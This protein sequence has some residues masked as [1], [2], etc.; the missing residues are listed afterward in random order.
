M[1]NKNFIFYKPQSNTRE[2]FLDF[3]KTICIIFVVVVNTLDSVS[4][5]FNQCGG[6]YWA[7]QAIPLFLIITGFLFAR[8]YENKNLTKLSDYY[9]PKY[10]FSKLIRYIVPYLFCM[11]VETIIFASQGRLTAAQF[12]INMFR[13]GQGP[14]AYYFWTIIE[15]VFIYPLVFALIKKLKFNGLF[16]TFGITL[17][18]DLIVFASQMPEIVYR[19]IAI[20]F[21]FI[22]SFG[23]YLYLAIKNN[24]KYKWYFAIP[25]FCIGLVLMIL[26]DYCHIQMHVYTKWFKYC[27]IANL[28]CI[29]IASLLIRKF[30]MNNQWWWS[31]IGKATWN[32]YLTQRV[33]LYNLPRLSLVNNFV[34]QVFINELI[35]LPLGLL[36]WQVE[37]PLSNLII[38]KIWNHQKVSSNNM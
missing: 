25:A 21:I 36:F 20:R 13:G 32:I 4:K 9:K 8:S 22:I 27:E 38:K 37:S 31:I 26:V 7:G 14:G 18:W 11:V 10:I 24:I 3:L 15:L 29:P 2:Y 19:F 30:K 16:I 33:F 28:Y 12:F 23:S 17:V 1:S 34:G 6:N 35:I 5:E